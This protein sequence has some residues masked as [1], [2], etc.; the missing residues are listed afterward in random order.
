VGRETHA[1]RGF[2]APSTSQIGENVPIFARKKL[3]IRVDF[4]LSYTQF[5]FRRLPV[6]VLAPGKFVEIA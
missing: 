6:G 4:G 1:Q 2:S 3:S 5:L